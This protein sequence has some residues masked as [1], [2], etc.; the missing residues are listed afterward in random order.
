MICYTYKKSLTTEQL[1]K[2]KPNS[3][4]LVCLSQAELE[5]YYAGLGFRPVER[6][7]EYPVE[8]DVVAAVPGQSFRPVYYQNSPVPLADFPLPDTSRGIYYIAI[9]DGPY[10]YWLDIRGT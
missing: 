9:H 2:G 10:P 1:I 5:K 8:L 3:F 7:S 6:D 4:I